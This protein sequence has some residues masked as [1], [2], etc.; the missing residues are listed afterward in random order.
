[1]GS[2]ESRLNPH[3][4][5]AE[6]C[7]S[8]AEYGIGNFEGSYEVMVYPLKNNKWKGVEEIYIDTLVHRNV[9]D[10]ARMPVNGALHWIADVE[11]LLS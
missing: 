9:P 5:K 11:S 1:M 10:R 2:Q 7:L 6:K 8:Y 4:P 3:F